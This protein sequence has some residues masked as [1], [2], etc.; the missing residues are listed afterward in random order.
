MKQVRQAHISGRCQDRGERLVMAY[1]VA[2]VCDG[3]KNISNQR[4]ENSN[5]VRS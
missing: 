1:A 3:P 4:E 2:S 5:A